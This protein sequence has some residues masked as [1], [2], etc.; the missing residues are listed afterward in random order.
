MLGAK[1]L[2]ESASL[3]EF[4]YLDTLEFVPGASIHMVIRLWKT[5]LKDRLIPDGSASVKLTF[6]KTDG[7]QL[8]KTATVVDAGDRSI[9][10]VDITDVESEDLVG[11]NVLVT[12]DELG[13]GTKIK[14]T[15]I[16]SALSKIVLDGCA[17]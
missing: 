13:D 9:L 17:C 8:E 5:E 15:V 1:L 11:G 7:T 4:S 6:N 16:Q 12:L 10:S 2:N 3:N 14:K